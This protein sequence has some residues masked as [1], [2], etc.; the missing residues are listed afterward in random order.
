MLFS[1]A[2][3]PGTRVSLL[4]AGFWPLIWH[5]WART[6]GK[7]SVARNFQPIPTL[8]TFLVEYEAKNRADLLRLML[9]RCHV[10]FAADVGGGNLMD[11]RL[12]LGALQAEEARRREAQ[13]NKGGFSGGGAGAVGAAGG[14]V[15]AAGRRVTQM[16]RS[17][18]EMLAG[19]GAPQ[20]GGHG[21]RGSGIGRL[22]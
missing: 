20:K 5:S 12:T 19:G 16:V 6:N 21:G 18:A 13:R 1:L 11:Q 3:Y 4:Q 15:A 22:V 14:A 9:E 7:T 2:T 17:G 10:H 8:L